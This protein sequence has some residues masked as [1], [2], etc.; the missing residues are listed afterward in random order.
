MNKVLFNL[1]KGNT[2]LFGVMFIN[3]IILAN[4]FLPEEIGIIRS[5]NLYSSIIIVIGT[6]QIHS[7]ILKYVVKIPEDYFRIFC[8]IKFV[9]ILSL[10]IS[11]IY[12]IIILIFFYNSENLLAFILNGLVLI[13]L[14]FFNMLQNFYIVLNESKKIT[15]QILLFG[16]IIVP[17]TFCIGYFDININYYFLGLFISYLILL[18]PWINIIKTSKQK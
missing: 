1:L 18:Y 7:S 15:I 11:I 14:I 4:Y 8:S 6:F 10:I 5:L 3:S 12:F 9:S 17:L 16:L 13:P 2:L